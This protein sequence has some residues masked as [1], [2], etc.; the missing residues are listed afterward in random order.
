MAAA[1]LEAVGL[2]ASVVNNRGLSYSSRN[3]APVS[4][5]PRSR[6]RQMMVFMQGAQ[7][8]AIFNSFRIVVFFVQD[9][10]LKKGFFPCYRLWL[11]YAAGT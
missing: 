10:I 7:N 3:K 9:W 1:E 8:T 4:A 6:Q 5:Y 11:A 2:S